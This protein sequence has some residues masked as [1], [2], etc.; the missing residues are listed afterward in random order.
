MHSHRY[1]VI[2]D[3]ALGRVGCAA[4]EGFNIACNDGRTSLV[5]DLDQSAL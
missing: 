5:A 2:I 3:G 4:F 1:R